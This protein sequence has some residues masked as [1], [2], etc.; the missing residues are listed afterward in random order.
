M[1]IKEDTL[2]D[3]NEMNKYPSNEI[4]IITTGSQGEPMSAL[5]RISS[6]EHKR[7]QLQPEDLVI[8]SATPI[9]GNEKLFLR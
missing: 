9:P 1:K 8:I 4:T 6:S 5:S 3:I 7:I 2:I